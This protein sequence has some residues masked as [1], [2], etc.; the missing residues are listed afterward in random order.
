[1]LFQVEHDD[2]STTEFQRIHV[3]PGGDAIADAIADAER[4]M[5]RD[6]AI[7]CGYDERSPSFYEVAVRVRGVWLLVKPY[8]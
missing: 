7:L 4:I 5:P 6:G 3:A 2:G 8:R 1:M